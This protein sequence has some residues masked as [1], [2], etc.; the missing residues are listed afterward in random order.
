MQ[1]SNHSRRQF[2]RRSA[3]LSAGAA[4]LGTAGAETSLAAPVDPTPLDDPTNRQGEYVDVNG[5][6]IFYQVAGQ[7]T[8]LLLIHGYPLSGALFSRVRDALAAH[9][10]VI[11]IDLRGYGKSTAPGVPDTIAIYAQDALAVLDSLG[12]QRAIVGGMSMGGPIAL[13]MYQRAPNRFQGLIL[14]DTNAFAATPAEAG[15]ER[16]FAD[17]SRQGGAAALVPLLLPIMLTGD[18]RAHQPQLVQYL[19]AVITAATTDAA[20]GGALA[21]ATRPDYTA[22]LG[23]ISVPTL[24]IVGQEDP[25]Y[26]FE[27]AQMMQQK[28]PNSTLTIIPGGAHATIFE[29]PQLAAKAILDWAAG[30]PVATMPGLP[31]TGGGGLRTGAGGGLQVLALAG[32]GAVMAGL[33]A[34]RFATPRE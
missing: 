9:Y 29:V 19:T 24:I 3:L 14:I 31:N 17:M 10:R 30:K 4:L 11:T 25:L 15:E 7:G 23:Q 6:H 16:G 21:L 1:P 18:T 32:L 28:I 27:I 34:H 13:E 5:A 26:P 12:I 20:V 8:P 33:L 2:L 22:L